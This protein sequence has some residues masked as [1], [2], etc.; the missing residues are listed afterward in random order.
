MDLGDEEKE[1]LVGGLAIVDAS[2]QCFSS[3]FF[4]IHIFFYFLFIG[5]CGM[6]ILLH[7]LIGFSLCGGCLLE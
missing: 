5:I 3:F 2:M 6:C 4:G 1:S 7:S